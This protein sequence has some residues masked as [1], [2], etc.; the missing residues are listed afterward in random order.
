M[1]EQE[2]RRWLA[3]WVTPSGGSLDTGTTNFYVN[4]VINVEQAENINM[5]EEFE[6]D[7]MASVY[8]LYTYSANDERNNRPNPTNLDI[9]KRIRGSIADI[10]S[11][12]N[13]YRRFCL[14][15]SDAPSYE[16]PDNNNDSNANTDSSTT[17]GLERDMQE[18]IREA[19]IQLETGLEIIDGG[20]ERKVVS[21]F[22]DILAKDNKGNFVVIEL[23][24]GKAS[25]SV[26]AQTLGYMVDIADEEKKDINQVRGIIV[27][28][29]FNKRI[30]TA[31][32]A[33]PTLT[34]KAYTYSFDFN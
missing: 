27:A 4:S 15:A 28:K 30:E 5:D 7:S 23:K 1:R 20:V 16:A 3:N 19:I 13:H 22:I 25:D 12:L 32:R 9:P 18:A 26:I 6:K 17:F 31:A 21:G 24:A 11:A 2:F 34:L 33:V 10:R 29:S 8:Q 14:G